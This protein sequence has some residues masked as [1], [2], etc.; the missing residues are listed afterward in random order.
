M[1]LGSFYNLNTPLGTFGSSIA[2][3]GDTCIIGSPGEEYRYST[4]E[5]KVNIGRIHIFRKSSTGIF[6]QGAS[7]APEN[8]FIAKDAFFGSKVAI[9]N[10]YAFVLSPFT[11]FYEK[12]NITIYDINCTFAIPPP[13][14][15]IPACALVTFDNKN[16]ILDSITGTYMLSYT[17]QL[18]GTP[19]DGTAQF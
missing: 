4:G 19:P 17:C 6:S 9:Y 8:D 12:S 2:F 3:R 15:G 14:I 18:G 11:P 16:F 10:N 7:I 5:T 1:A 13:Q